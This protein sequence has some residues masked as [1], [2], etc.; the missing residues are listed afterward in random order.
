MEQTRESNEDD[1]RFLVGIGNQVGVESRNHIVL[2]SIVHVDVFEILKC[3][4]YIMLI[5]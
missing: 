5:R 2:D 1:R 4:V 3:L